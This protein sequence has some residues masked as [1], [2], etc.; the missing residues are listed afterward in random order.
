MRDR[1]G[2]SKEWRGASGGA[3]FRHLSGSFRHL[4]GIFQASFKELHE[5]VGRRRGA[6][7]N[8]I[9]ARGR[10]VCTLILSN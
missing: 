9:K 10:R 8:I 4:S 5:G 6:H 1:A 2:I 3:P 7:P